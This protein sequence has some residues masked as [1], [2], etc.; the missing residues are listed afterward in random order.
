MEFDRIFLMQDAFVNGAFRACPEGQIDDWKVARGDQE[1][2]KRFGYQMGSSLCDWMGTGWPAFSLVSQRFVTALRE[3]SFT[4]WKSYAAEV[5]RKNGKLIEGYEVL[6]VTGR[7]GP[8]DHSKEKKVRKP[9]PVPQG[10]AYDAW[11]GMYFD[12]ES[13]DGSDLFTPEGT[14]VTVVTE[15]VKSALERVGIT[16]VHFKPLTEFERT[17]EV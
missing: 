9:P 8:L 1:P 14:T 4:G 11:I 16:N 2:P 17:W 5:H 3:G 15:P 13:W 12:P 10:Q 7:C 6:I